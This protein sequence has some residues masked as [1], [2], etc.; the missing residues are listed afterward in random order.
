M[1]DYVGKALQRANG[2]IL[3]GTELESICASEVK[4]T[5]IKW[6]WPDRFAIG[7]LGIIAGLHL[8]G[9][10]QTLAFVAA[11]VT[12][13]GPWP[14]NE[15]QAPSGSVVVFSDEATPTTP[16]CHASLPQVPI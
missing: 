7:K 13:A 11:Q 6:L 9:K 8:E 2:R 3:H 15:G 10:G 14:M 1:R 4:M 5:G 16:W 12:N